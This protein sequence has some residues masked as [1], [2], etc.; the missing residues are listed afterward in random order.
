MDHSNEAQSIVTALSESPLDVSAAIETVGDERA[1]GTAVFIGTVRVEAAVAENT[2]K[3]VMELEY[4]AHV[5]LAE[6]KLRAIAS[7][8]AE[9]WKLTRVTAIHRI[10]TCKLGEPTVVIACSADHRSGALEACRWIIDEIKQEVPIWK[11][12]VYADG[13]A[14][15][16]GSP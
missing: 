12:E 15:V 3:P 1:G 6:K 14:W 8:A 7:S 2:D 9:R 11:R 13:S 16:E 10:G 4:E 5:P